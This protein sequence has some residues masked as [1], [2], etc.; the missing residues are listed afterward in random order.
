MRKIWL[1]LT[2][3]VIFIAVCG[4]DHAPGADN[5][6]RIRL[7][8]GI[9]FLPDKIAE[10]SPV[11]VIADFDRRCEKIMAHLRPGLAR[12]GVIGI[13]PFF[14]IRT[15]ERVRSSAVDI[16]QELVKKAEEKTGK[17]LNTL[18][19]YSYSTAGTLGSQL[20]FMNPDLFRG[21]ILA[22][23]YQPDKKNATRKNATRVPVLLLNGSQDKVFHPVRAVK[24]KKFLADNGFDVHLDIIANATHSDVLKKHSDVF[25]K[26]ILKKS[27]TADRKK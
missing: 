3:L 12:H 27:K 22:A 10:T 11:V 1:T 25:L 19:V 9:I 6:K 14:R 23:T 17:Q 4:V 8:Q 26:W 5:G 24:T 7:K 15:D 2:V 20:A 18:F 21:L 13:A 16:L